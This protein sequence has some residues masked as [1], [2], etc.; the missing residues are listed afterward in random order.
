MAIHLYLENMGFRAIGRVL[1]LSNIA[2]LKW[3]RAAGEWIQNYHQQHKAQ[4]SGS[5]RNG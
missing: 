5:N 4:A 3:I 1:G 2:F